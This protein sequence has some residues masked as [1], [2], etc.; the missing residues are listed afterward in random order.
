[1]LWQTNHSESKFVEELYSCTTRYEHNTAHKA[2]GEMTTQTNESAKSGCD[3]GNE[4]EKKERE[5]WCESDMEWKANK[6][7]LEVCCIRL[8][9]CRRYDIDYYVC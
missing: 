5:K 6:R 2:D 3:K 4:N 7:K 9:L 8:R 1:M